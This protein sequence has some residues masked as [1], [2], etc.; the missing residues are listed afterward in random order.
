MVGPK[1]DTS[2]CSVAQKERV[3][4]Q[5]GLFSCT[6]AFCSIVKRKGRLIHHRASHELRS[7]L[8]P[9]ATRPHADLITLR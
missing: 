4:A 8:C 6:C 2:S 5:V 3:Q 1:L 9:E 7:L